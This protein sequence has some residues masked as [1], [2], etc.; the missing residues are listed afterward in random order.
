MDHPAFQRLRLPLGRIMRGAATGFVACRRGRFI[1]SR[2]A[3]VNYD[4]S[5]AAR[6]S[7]ALSKQC[8]ATVDFQN[9][10]TEPSDVDQ[11]D[12]AHAGGVGDCIHPLSS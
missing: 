7:A 1:D 2:G 8:G 9:L 6:A 11:I 3:L 10:G 5:F 4:E 12:H